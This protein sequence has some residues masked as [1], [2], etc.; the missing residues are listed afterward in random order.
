MRL[1]CT[2]LQCVMRALRC[3]LTSQ[4]HFSFRHVYVSPLPSPLCY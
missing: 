1:R 4:T 3:V 2:V